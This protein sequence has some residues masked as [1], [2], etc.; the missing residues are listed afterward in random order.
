MELERIDK[1]SHCKFRYEDTAKKTFYLYDELTGELLLTAKRVG[2]DFYIS[3]YPEFP[4]L[5]NEKNAKQHVHRACA[6]LHFCEPRPNNPA[7]ASKRHRLR[8]RVGGRIARCQLWST[9]CDY[10]DN[11]L[12]KYVCGPAT[13]TGGGFYDAL[14]PHKSRKSGRKATVGEVELAMLKDMGCRQLLADFTQSNVEI[15]MGKASSSS[16]EIVEARRLTVAVPTLAI[17]ERSEQIHHC[18]WC[19]RC[20]RDQDTALQMTSTVPEWNEENER[21][22]M[23]FEEGHVREHSAKN[24]LVHEVPDPLSSD[25]SPKSLKNLDLSPRSPRKGKSVS[26]RRYR[27]DRRSCLQFGKSSKRLFTLS[28]RYPMSAMQGFGIALSHFN[29]MPDQ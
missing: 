8:S 17:D 28:Y 25:K 12:A 20:P 13:H 18:G 29:W 4:D 15:K 9:S 26:P 7:T 3:Q 5:I 21:L 1:W 19:D 16:A 10:C 22:T 14:A 2:S 27:D 6:L 23:C 24:F 11:T